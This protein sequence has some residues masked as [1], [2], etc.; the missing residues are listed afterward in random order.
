MM[1][2]EFGQVVLIAFPF[3]SGSGAKERPALAL[4]DNGDPDVLVARSTSQTVTTKDD[5]LIKN[6]K[7]AGL[8]VISTVRLHKV[9]T[10]DK[11]LI[12]TSL[13]YLTVDD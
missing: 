6:W 8:L 5:L 12:D 4:Y 3:T 7:V 1:N 10:L 9:A 2:Y 13:S 11:R